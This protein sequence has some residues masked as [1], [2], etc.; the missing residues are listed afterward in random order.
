MTR[1]RALEL[2]KKSS[3]AAHTDALASMLL[4]TVAIKATPA[5]PDSL[6]QG[7][8]R[9]GGTPD[10]PSDW[11][12]P[13]DPANKPLGF[14][15]QFDLA[16]IA[17]HCNESLLPTTG[18]LCFFYDVTSKPW[19][20]D[21]AD[22][23][24]W[25]VDYFQ[26]DAASLCRA[27]PPEDR[28]GST[29]TKLCSLQFESTFTL[30]REEFLTKADPAGRFTRLYDGEPEE[31]GKI[32]IDIGDFEDE[33]EPLIFLTP[34]DGPDHRLLGNAFE[35]QG[36]MPP[37]FKDIIR[38]EPTP[39]RERVNPFTGERKMFPGKPATECA[40][41]LK[42]LL[43]KTNDWRLLLQLGSDRQGPGWMWGDMGRLYFWIPKS[44]LAQHDFSQ[45]WVQLQCG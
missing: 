33:L 19:G 22:A 1:E 14:L 11:Q 36:P 35:L 3:F 18:W 5:A 2:I 9:F 16:E 17:K 7:A 4:P 24:K 20:I 44:A 29:A 13:T 43:L 38:L 28:S 10:V 37:A 27:A 41:S 23:D 12:W 40:E 45:V 30:P 15:A 26:S 8:S 39:P 34:M 25:R 42:Q 21:T 31:P 6:A 32:G